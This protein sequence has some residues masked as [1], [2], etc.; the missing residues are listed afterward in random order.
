MCLFLPGR[1]R[2]CGHWSGHSAPRGEGRSGG[3]GESHRAS[4]LGVMSIPVPAGSP[5][6]LPARAFFT[7]ISPSLLWTAS[8]SATSK[9]QQGEGKGRA[10]VA[11]D[12]N[13]GSQ[14]F[15]GSSLSLCTNL[16]L[17]GMCRFLPRLRE[18]DV[19]DPCMEVLRQ[20]DDILRTRSREGVPPVP[21]RSGGPC[22]RRI[23]S[24]LWKES[25]RPFYP[26]SPLFVCDRALLCR[27]G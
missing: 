11:Q 21:N 13:S 8:P 25:I 16:L 19:P 6:S 24:R 4:L 7:S 5:H 20:G 23:L 3:L 12:Q 1:K 15:P 14:L 17:L 2:R 26:V 10:L 18:P 27:V 22:R 9:E